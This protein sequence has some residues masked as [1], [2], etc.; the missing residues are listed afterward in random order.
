MNV[1]YGYGEKIK[2]NLRTKQA[3]NRS[4]ICRR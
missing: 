2:V 4:N 3:F 1:I